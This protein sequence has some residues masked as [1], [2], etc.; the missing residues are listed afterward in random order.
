MAITELKDMR[1]SYAEKFRELA[2][3]IER[4][5]IQPLGCSIIIFWNDH[6]MTTMLKRELGF[7]HM[8][9]SGAHL[10]LAMDLGLAVDHTKQ[11]P[12]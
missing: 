12:T 11:E 7:N 5:A 1:P 4:S 6:S 2:D 8:T 3:L 10:R 9:A